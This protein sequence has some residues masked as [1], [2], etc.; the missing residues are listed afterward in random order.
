MP[1]RT[2]VIE[3]PLAGDYVKNTIYA[4]LA[5]LDCLQR[6]EAPFASHLL[7]PIVLDDTD[8]EERKLGMRAGFNLG[9]RLDVV[10]VY[11]DLG[12]SKGMEAGIARAQKRGA[13][14]EYRTIPNFA[15]KI[16]E[17]LARLG[18]PL[19]DA[20]DQP[21]YDMSKVRGLLRRR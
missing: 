18:L 10:A 14:I 16:D 9:D 5:M 11:T 13:P 4:Q 12:I 15:R 6:D 19:R 17:A 1:M 3:S 7:Y 8:A 21:I 2:V 20:T